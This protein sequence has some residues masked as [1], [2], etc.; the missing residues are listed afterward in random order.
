[1]PRIHAVAVSN[2]YPT[3]Q[4]PFTQAEENEWD[5]RAALHGSLAEQKKRKVG[6]VSEIAK[7]KANGGMVVNGLSISTDA[8]G[9]SLLAGAKHGGK[10]SRKVVTKTGR[11][12]LSKIQFEAVVSAADDFIQSVFDRQYDLGELID[13]AANK[14]QLDAIDIETGWPA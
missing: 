13:A 1:M 4:K 6:L 2:I 3:G 14:T 8:A 9:R 10:A 7:A 5:A 12:E 11:A